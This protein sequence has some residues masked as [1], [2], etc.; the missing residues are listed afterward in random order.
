MNP[1]R[2]TGGHTGS[3]ED[4]NPLQLRLFEPNGDDQL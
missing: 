4:S 2:G 3:S 1:E